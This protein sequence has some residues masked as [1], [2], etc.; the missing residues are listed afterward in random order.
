ML[1][2]I[3]LSLLLLTQEEV[4]HQSV[5]LYRRSLQKESYFYFA[6]TKEMI[7]YIDK[8]LYAV[9]FHIRIKLI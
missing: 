6:Q 3:I 2:D 1:Q 7:I 9:Y 4:F 8:D 5:P